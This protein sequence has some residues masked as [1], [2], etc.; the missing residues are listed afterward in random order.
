[1]ED[2]FDMEN[3]IFVIMVIIMCVAGVLTFFYESGGISNKKHDDHSNE[4]G[5]ERE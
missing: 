1:M 4:K 2:N 5:K 3:L